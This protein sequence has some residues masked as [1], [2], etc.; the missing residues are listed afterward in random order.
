M[1][2][3]SAEVGALPQP[4]ESQ[5]AAARIDRRTAMQMAFALGGI[6]GLGSAGRATEERH[7]I[8]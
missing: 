3:I 4:E 1:D 7:C 5:Y 8:G 6:A 2:D